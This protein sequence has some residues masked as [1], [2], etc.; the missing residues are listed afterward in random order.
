[1]QETMH[2][3]PFNESNDNDLF[4]YDNDKVTSEHFKKF[5]D[6]IDLLITNI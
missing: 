2:R 5:S 6:E 3:Y 1:M 4:N